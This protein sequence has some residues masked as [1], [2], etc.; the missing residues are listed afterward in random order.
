MMTSHCG[1]GLGRG[2]G[3]IDDGGGVGALVLADDVAVG[4]LRP[5]LELVGRGGAEGVAR[6]QED[7]FALV[8]QLVRE[9]AD[10]G[11]LADAVDA[12]DE[13]DRRLRVEPQAGV[14]DVQHVGEDGAQGDLGL[15]DGLDV[16]LADGLAQAVHDGLGGVHAEVG[17]DEALFQIVVE[18]VVQLAGGEDAADG[19]GSLAQPLLEFF[20]KSHVS[21]S[22]L[23]GL[24]VEKAKPKAPLSGADSPYQGEMS[25]RDKRGRDAV[26]RRLT[27]RLSQI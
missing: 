21:E 16:L 3:V 20:K 25:R 18:V 19:A 4:A 24:A 23:D 26:S 14:A 12:D 5:D 10:G 15:V 7:L 13:D 9:L 22:F 27:E 8:A 1:V 6:A 2:D 11:G 17:D